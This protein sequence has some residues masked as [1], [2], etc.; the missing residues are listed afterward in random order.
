MSFDVTFNE[1]NN[2]G[3]QALIANLNNDLRNEWTHL[4][5]YL[6]SAALVQGLHATEYKE[7]LQKEANKELLHVGQFSDMLIGLGVSPHE[8]A[9]EPHYDK[10][11]SLTEPK[12]ILAHALKL[13]EEVVRNYCQ[14][15]HE[16]EACGCTDGDWVH[17]FLEAQI[18]DSREDVDHLKQILRGL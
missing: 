16:A 6:H 15:M 18:Q 5:F 3:L 1:K 14:R 11:P 9:K 4:T 17:I 8:L 10:V 12:A 7:L 13:E 2:Q